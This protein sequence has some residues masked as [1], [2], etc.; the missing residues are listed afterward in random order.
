LKHRIRCCFTAYLWKRIIDDYYLIES[1]NIVAYADDMVLVQ[2]GLM[3]LKNIAI[4]P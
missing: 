4:I 2:L 3:R 1:L